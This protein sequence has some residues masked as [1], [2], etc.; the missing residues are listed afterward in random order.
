MPETAED[1]GRGRVPGGLPRDAERH[2]AGRD[3]LRQAFLKPRR[4]QLVVALLLALVGFA[5][6]TQV[7]A[8]ETDDTYAGLREQDLIDIL[9][10]LAGTSQR[11]QDEIQTLQKTRDDL[12]SD[13]SARQAAL[14]QARKQSDTLSILA[15]VVPVRGPGVVITIK[16]VNGQVDVGAFLDMVEALRTA[17][18][19]AMEIN[20]KVRVVAQ[21]SFEDGTGGLL[22][23]GLLLSA[24]FTVDA[25]GDPD[26]LGSALKFPDGPVDEFREDDAARL[27]Y[28]AK[29]AV[30]I[31]SVRPAAAADEAQP[32]Q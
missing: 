1:D 12:Q 17:G 22:V 30:T 7:R 10:G 15:G 13:T 32:Q 8:N 27:T 2:D 25:I 6:V 14:D 28:V 4:S 26:A 11:A 23:D 31:S 19:E 20:G 16:E 3:R 5:A 9:N 29:D 18:A 24:P 21:T